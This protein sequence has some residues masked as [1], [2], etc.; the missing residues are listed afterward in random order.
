MKIFSWL[1]DFKLRERTNNEYFS[2]ESDG[3]DPSAEIG[4][5]EIVPSNA[6]GVDFDPE[7]SHI[8]YINGVLIVEASP[9]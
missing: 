7:N 1:V 2:P 4:L 9:I 3:G 6:M 5:Y 8:D